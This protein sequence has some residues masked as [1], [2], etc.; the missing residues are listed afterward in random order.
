[1]GQDLKFLSPEF[2]VPELG[3]DSWVQDSASA[4]SKHFI[5]W[6]SWQA[7]WFDLLPLLAGI[8][9][10]FPFLFALKSDRSRGGRAQGS[11]AGPLPRSPG[12]STPQKSCQIFVPA[13]APSIL[14]SNGCH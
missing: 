6:P 4:R 5:L 8:S 12:N 3:M 1:M 11:S 10:R 9:R 14:Q 7:T 13:S 2:A